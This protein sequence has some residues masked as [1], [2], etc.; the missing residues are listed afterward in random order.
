MQRKDA[1]PLYS[2]PPSRIGCSILQTPVQDNGFVIRSA[3]SVILATTTTKA[4]K[5]WWGTALLVAALTKFTYVALIGVLIIAGLGVPI[6]ED[7]PLILAGYMCHEQ[8][9]PIIDIGK[10]VP[11]PLLMSLAGMFGVLIG[12]SIVFSIG[13]RGIDGNNF[14][15]RH[16]R[17]VMNS[18]RRE[19]VES[20]FARHGNL[21]VFCGRFMPGFRSLVFA[22]AGM[23]KMSYPRFLLIDGF[24]AAISVPLFVFIGYKFAPHIKEVWIWLERIKHIALPV[25]IALVVGLILIYFVRRRR[26]AVN[27]PV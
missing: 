8:V 21:T 18:K 12:D 10:E 17:K 5:E 15:A 3:I 26:V 16:I 20:H 19:K 14:V 9:S 6:P 7:I 23:S 22:F 25:G 13:R 27:T 1:R 24:A 2:A 4:A 11:D